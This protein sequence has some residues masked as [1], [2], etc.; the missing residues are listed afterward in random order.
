[1]SKEQAKLSINKLDESGPLHPLHHL[2]PSQNQPQRAF[3]CL[4][5]EARTLTADWYGE[6]GGGCFARTWDGRDVEFAIT[7]ELTANEINELMSDIAPACAELLAEAECEPAS[8]SCIEAQ[9]HDIQNACLVTTAS[10]GVWDAADFF[11][12]GP[13]PASRQEALDAAA[14]HEGGVT[15]LYLDLYLED[16][17]EDAAIV[18]EQ[19]GESK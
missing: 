10:G 14:D 16:A 15:L 7:P 19:R 5:T 4:D 8:R 11:D 12:G 6:I 17:A 9:V 13:V 18:A 3:I 2:Y 1:M